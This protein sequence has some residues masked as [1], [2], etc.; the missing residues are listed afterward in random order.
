M[1]LEGGSMPKDL[2]AEPSPSLPKDFPKELIPE[3]IC[4]V[5]FFDL[6]RCAYSEGIQMTCPREYKN[7][8]ECKRERDLKLFYNLQ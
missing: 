5:E 6:V 1:E 7:F 8:L 4:E 3:N 2:T